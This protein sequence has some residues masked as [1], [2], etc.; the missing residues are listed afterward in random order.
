LVAVLPV[1]T[2][3]Q[4]AIVSVGE[5]VWLG[6]YTVTGFEADADHEYAELEENPEPPD[7]RRYAVLAV[8]I[9]YDGEPGDNADEVIERAAALS[10]RLHVP[11]STGQVR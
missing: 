5:Q 10:L 9:R 6:N 4:G 1:L 8:T 7:G 2:A 11:S 3:A